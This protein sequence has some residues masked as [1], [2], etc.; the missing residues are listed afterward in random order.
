M[1]EKVEMLNL[2]SNVDSIET[3]DAETLTSGESDQ[4][5]DSQFDDR[6]INKTQSMGPMHCLAKVMYFFATLPHW[7]VI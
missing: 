5:S 7:L 6:Y 1:E 2:A 4:D 3:S